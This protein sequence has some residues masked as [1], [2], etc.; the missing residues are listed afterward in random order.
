MDESRAPISPGPDTPPEPPSIWERELLSRL[1]FAS[2]REQ[3][4]ARRWSIFF[5]FSVLVYLVTLLGLY[6]PRDLF[7][8][9]KTGRH[10]ALVDVQG[11]I[12]QTTEASADKIV[13]GL[14]AAFEDKDTAG[15]ILRINSPGGS[16][17]Q[18]GYV[19]DEIVRLRKKYPDT[20]LYAVIT[21]VCASG[22][23]YIAAAADQIYADKSSIVGS[24]GV[25]MNAFGFV[26]AM[27]KLGIE[28]RLLVAGDHK[29][30]L[31]PFSPIRPEEV[32]H[33]EGMLGELHQQFIQVVKSG[34]GDRLKGG[35]ELYSGLVWSGERSVSLGLV[36]GLGSSGYVARE[37]I[38]AEEIV[39]FTARRGYLERFA[40]RVG[41]AM[42]T[43]LSSR[44]GI[45]ANGIR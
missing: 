20:P 9:A 24:I 32:E 25:I 14:R 42:A 22:G 8:G 37:L 43:T 5:K 6:M 34:R 31:D 19:N 4:R 40:E 30:F 45:D 36:D 12:S 38:G 16:P 35:D 11:V 3:R 18:A 13:G 44:I 27:D 39:D 33:V 17:V 26:G 10:S 2:L 29:G 1:A 28:R 23:Y 41:A 21:D 15:V 7:T